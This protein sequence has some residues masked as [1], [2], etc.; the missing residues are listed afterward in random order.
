MR[1]ASPIGSRQ[2]PNGMR[3][4]ASKRQGEIPRVGILASR[5][6]EACIAVNGVAWAGATYVPLGLRLPDE[7]LLTILSL[8]NLA[9]IVTDEEG[10]SRLNEPIV[11]AAPACVLALGRKPPAAALDGR[12][13][14]LDTG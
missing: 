8:C 10:A 6:A 9:A 14:W 13:G 3:A 2:H 1:R 12:V 4:A 11:R 5:S 7:R